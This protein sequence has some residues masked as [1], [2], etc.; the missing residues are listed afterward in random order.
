MKAA[1]LWELGQP[2]SIEEVE[3][4][5]PKAGEVRVKIGAAGIC[6]SDHHYMKK[7][8]SIATPAVLGHE[9]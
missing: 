2:L 8:G 3:L 6:R 5:P 1:V 9:G 4:D 7:E